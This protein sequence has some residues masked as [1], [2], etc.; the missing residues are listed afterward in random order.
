[1]PLLAPKVVI[2]VKNQRMTPEIMRVIRAFSRNGLGYAFRP[3]VFKHR[4]PGDRGMKIRRTLEELGTTYINV[5][6]LMSIRY[7]LFPQ[8]ILEELSKLQ[9][10]VPPF[11]FD[12]F[13]EILDEAYTDRGS[14]FI[15]IQE[16][17]L[18][19]AS[20]AQVHRAILLDGSEVAV[21]VRR[22]DIIEPVRRDIDALKMVAAFAQRFPLFRDVDI[23][24]IVE[25]F[26]RAMEGEMNFSNEELS[27]T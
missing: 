18:A 9:D 25:D 24:G 27:Q 6:Q 17:P 8:D 2:T 4:H 10:D 19:S 7:D 13:I 14:H 22:P 1:M 23:E 5:G 21:K 20:V 15:F 3:V 11:P 12:K 26:G 16:K